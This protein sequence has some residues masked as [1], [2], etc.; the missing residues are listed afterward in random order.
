MCL[1]GSIKNILTV[2]VEALAVAT[3]AILTGPLEALVVVAMLL[4]G[5]HRLET[6]EADTL[7][8]IF[9]LFA[10]ISWSVRLLL[11]GGFL[12]GDDLFLGGFRD[13]FD[14]GKIVGMQLSLLLFPPSKCALQ[15]LEL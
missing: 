13:G 8:N 5:E 4:T 7:W 12:L 1:S 6:F 2:L 10:T 9:S 3:C 15:T 14:Q 11:G